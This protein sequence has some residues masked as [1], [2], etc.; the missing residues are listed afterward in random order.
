[1]PRLSNTHQPFPGRRRAS[2]RALS[3]VFISIGLIVT[4]SCA[5]APEPKP[6]SDPVKLL[7]NV[8]VSLTPSAGIQT[9]EGTTIA[10]SATGASSSEDRK[11]DATQVVRELPVRVSLQYR[12]G[13]KYGS[14]LAELRGHTGPVEINLTLENLTVKP[15][16]IEYDAA[17]QTRADTAL[18]GAR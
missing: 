7:Q 8:R 16:V 18:V 13:T 15:R 1:M 12:A 14:D 9:V 6:I 10:V 2:G 17:G 4:T 5:S 11:Y 3:V